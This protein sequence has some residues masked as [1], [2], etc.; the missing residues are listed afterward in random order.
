MAANPT[1]KLTPKER[2]AQKQREKIT[3]LT[4]ITFEGGL[5]DMLSAA[6]AEGLRTGLRPVDQ[7][8]ENSAIHCN[9]EYHFARF[10]GP[11]STLA[12]LLYGIS[13]HLAKDSGNFSL[14][15]QNLKRF[16]NVTEDEAIYAA[17]SLLVAAGFWVVIKTQ[18]G[19]P[20]QYRPVGHEEWAAKHT[21]F[22]TR[23]WEFPHNE[24]TELRT[25]G[26][27]LHGIL[28]C[29][30]LFDH[31]IAGWRKIG[32]SDDEICEYARQFVR[33]PVYKQ[34][35]AGVAVRKGFGDYLRAKW[36]ATNLG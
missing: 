14:S 7:D 32:F 21:G 9:A 18:L 10:T 16:L 30:H 19:T 23:K 2:S 34:L 26:K 25:L 17:A 29:E 24:L 8:E 36:A 20:T 28:G 4:G 6:V 5:G 31:V 13:F 3:A 35:A 11:G 15:M 33:G 27:R 22:C 12:P 1:D